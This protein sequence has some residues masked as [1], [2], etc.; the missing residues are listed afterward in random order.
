[1]EFG[2]WHSFANRGIFLFLWSQEML[3]SYSSVP[4][5][6]KIVDSLLRQRQTLLPKGLNV[7]EIHSRKPQHYRTR[8]LE[9]F[10]DSSRLILVASDISTR[11]MNYPGVTLVI[12][13]V[14]ASAIPFVRRRAPAAIVEEL[15]SGG[16][17][18]IVD[19]AM[20]EW[21]GVANLQ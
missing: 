12:Q 15:A 3:L 13:S 20:D 11:G 16:K 17:D 18:K 6:E 14:P 8:I 10:R 4:D 21:I 7:R 5:I 1:M 19:G 9:E 2:F